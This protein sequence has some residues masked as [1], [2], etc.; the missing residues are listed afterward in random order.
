LGG[1]KGSLPMK[2]WTWDIFAS[3]DTTNHLQ[4]NYNAVLKSQVQ[5][6]LNAPDGGNSLCAG[7]FDPFGLL[8][9]SVISTQCQG[10]MSTTAH[11]TE[12]L[13]QTNVQATLQGTLFTLPAGDLVAAV[14]ADYRRNTY[15]F[16]PDSN[17][18]SQNIEAVIASSPSRGA[19][20]VREFAGQ[21]DVPLLSDLPLVEKLSLGAA[22]RRSNYTT[23]GGVNSYEGDLKWTPVKSFLVRGGYQRAV[24]APNIG[25]LFS[26]AS[27]SQIA[28]GTPPAAVGDPCDIR[29]P[30]RTGSNGAAVRT[31]CLAQGLPAA[32]IDSYTFPTTATAGNAHGN[33]NLRP[34]TADTYNVGFSWTSHLGSPLLSNLSASVDYYNIKIKDVISVVP[35]LT[36]L[37]KCYNLDSSNPGYDPGNEFCQLLHRDAQG[38]LQVI[39]TP[40]LNLGGLKTDGVDLQLN[41]S[42]GLAD[43]GWQG[44]SARVFAN[45]GL[46]WLHGYSIQTVPGARFQNYVGTNTISASYNVS[47]TFPKWKAVTTIGYSQAGATASL[48]WRYQNAM[49]DVTAVTTPANPGVGVP[50]YS[51]VDLL[52][53]YELNKQWQLRAGITNLGNHAPVFVSSSQFSTDPS[54][55]DVVG[56]SY[57]V[58]V[59]LTL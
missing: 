16:S 49:Q 46:G 29:S 50:A 13:T 7:G 6:L 22:L 48:R 15:A 57:Y 44:T 40:Y 43:L 25:E 19:I 12:R 5:N 14:L 53:S 33:P 32:V 35:G 8:H 47:S 36:A 10:Y 4:T 1:L 27:G 21:V 51:L 23:S 37:S 24:R 26:A 3:Y 31:L 45:S 39:D 55:F 42:V 11:S 2:D 59:H 38:L 28:F 58:G 41:W 54:V 30:A 34:E 17:L 52:G 56:R 18:A 9:S 20:G